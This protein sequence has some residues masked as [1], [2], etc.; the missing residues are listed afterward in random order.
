MRVLYL[1]NR[2]RSTR[3]SRRYHESTREPAGNW[4]EMRFDTP[5]QHPVHPV[6]RCYSF[7][8]RFRIDRMEQAD[9]ADPEHPFMESLSHARQR[10]GHGYFVSG[11]P[12]VSMRYPAHPVHRCFSSTWI[13][14]IFRIERREQ[15]DPEYQ[16]LE[17]TAMRPAARRT[18]THR[19]GKP[20]PFDTSSC[21]SCISMFL[22]YIDQQD[23]Q[24]KKGRG[25]TNPKDRYFCFS[26]ALR[27]VTPRRLNLN[28]A[29]ILD[30]MCEGLEFP[31]LPKNAGVPGGTSRLLGCYRRP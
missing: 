7:T 10:G 31:V 27:L 14:R 5:P 24:D 1:E 22:S 21:P 12:G 17:S 8:W 30:E 25:P 19:V 13:D 23:I 6:H 18:S 4:K 26:P 29:I 9:Q 3:F 28:W 11:S 2:S 15:S 20:W 16:C